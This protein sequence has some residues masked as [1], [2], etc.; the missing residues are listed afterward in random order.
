MASVL[1]SAVPH[2]KSANQKCRCRGRRDAHA[3][4]QNAMQTS[5]ETEFAFSAG[6]ELQA[7]FAG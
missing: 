5:N 6:E 1:T 4:C 3:I 7:K 2:N